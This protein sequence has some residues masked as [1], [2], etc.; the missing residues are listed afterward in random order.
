MKDEHI[1]SMLESRPLSADE[2]D[3]AQIRAHASIC[4]SCR[5]A[6]E[7]ADVSSLLLKA[8]AN[9]TF[10]P[11]PFFQTRVLAALREQQAENQTWAW[12]RLWRTAAGLASSM[13]ATVAILAILTFVIPGTQT[14]ESQTAAPFANAYSAEAVVLDDNA[15]PDD[16]LSDNDVLATLYDADDNVVK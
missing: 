15:A 9:E 10:E 3:F 13:V 8:R 5:K 6:Y 16:Q 11:S 7:A 1:I 14:T 12:S 4:E 2:N